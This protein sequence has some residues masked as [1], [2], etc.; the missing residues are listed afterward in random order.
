MNKRVD[1]SVIV[2]AYNAADYIEECLDSILAQDGVN[3]E[4]ITIDDGSTDSTGAI[5]DVY[6]NRYDNV[7]VLH[8]E[9]G[10]ISSAR[11]AGLQRVTGKYVCYL[12]SDDYYVTGALEQAFKKCEEKNADLLFMMYNNF[13]DNDLAEANYP[14]KDIKQEIRQGVYPEN[15]ITGLDLMTIFK[16]NKEYNVMVCMQ[17]VRRDLLE[18]NGIHFEKGIIFEDAPYTLNV[19]LHAQRAIAWNQS[20]FNY[21]IRNNSLCHRPADAERCYGAFKGFLYMMEYVRSAKSISESNIEA[22]ASEV[23]RRYRFTTRT[24]ITID[25]REREK[26]REMFSAE[27][28]VFFEALIRTY[29]L[30]DSQK[31]KEMKKNEKQLAEINRQQAELEMLRTQLENEMNENK[32]LRSSWSFKIGKKVVGPLSKIKKYLKGNK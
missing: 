29:G 6:A 13:Y 17:M 23:K 19:L 3:L 32:R 11:N 16:Q 24:Y 28:Y 7:K 2:P 9:N 1:V 8:Q 27:E 30:L 10:G 12:D 31:K 18:Q 22:V 14:V 20:L 15:P 25:K 21:R 26:L 5:L 4:I